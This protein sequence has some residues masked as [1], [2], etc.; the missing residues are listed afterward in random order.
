M[1]NA[2]GTVNL[3]ILIGRLGQNPELKYLPDGAAVLTLSLATDSSYKDSDGNQQNETEWHRVI[4]WRK[5]AEVVA[6]YSKKGDQLYVEGKLKTRSWETD[7][8]KKY[9]TE[10]QA[11]SQQFLSGRSGGSGAPESS[12]PPPP[13]PPEDSNEPVDDLPF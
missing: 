4:F 10:I 7:G 9:S 8:V 13:E 6:Q 3:V 11:Q 12:T 1:Y 2:K 5:Q